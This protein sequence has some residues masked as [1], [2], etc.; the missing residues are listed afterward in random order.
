MKQFRFLFAFIVG[1]LSSAFVLSAVHA[2]QASGT[3]GPIAITGDLF[4]IDEK[5]RL[6][7]FTGNVVAK[8]TNFTLWAPRLV[9]SYG[10]GGTKDLKEVRAE[11]GIRIDQ[12]DQTATSD[13]GIYDPNTRILRMIGNVKT[14]TKSSGNVVESAEMVVDLKNDTTSFVGASGDNGRVTAVFGQ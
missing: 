6:A 11:G 14:T 10:E 2:Q 1:V 9:A 8:Q 7:K 13:Y 4:E 3:A 12:P 5:A